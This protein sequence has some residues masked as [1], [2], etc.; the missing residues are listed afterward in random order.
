M[1]T[2][3]QVI[4]E[5]WGH[6]A[7]A[8]HDIVIQSMEQY[9]DLKTEEFK[10]AVINLHGMTQHY[11]TFIENSEETDVLR[12]ELKNDFVE[13]MT[14]HLKRYDHLIPEI[15]HKDTPQRIEKIRNNCYR[16]L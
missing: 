11:L 8:P 9:A 2:A 12:T 6:H 15:D 7:D 4:N 14:N 5:N 13:I 16:V 1:K 10:E 3:E